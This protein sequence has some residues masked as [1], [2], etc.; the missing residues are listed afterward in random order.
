MRS[1][2]SSLVNFSFCSVS[3]R[4]TSPSPTPVYTMARRPQD[5]ALGIL[6]EKCPEVQG[7]KW[8]SVLQVLARLPEG[9]GLQ[10]IVYACSFLCMKDEPSMLR[11]SSIEYGRAL[12][13]VNKALQN[14]LTC[15]SDDTLLA[16]LNISIYEVGSLVLR[17]SPVLSRAGLTN[18]VHACSLGKES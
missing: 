14:P 18:T 15:S 12:K 7:P 11:E 17:Y 3:S 9:S 8:M 5:A 1:D 4:Y 10:H 2:A 6:C 16:I 13:A